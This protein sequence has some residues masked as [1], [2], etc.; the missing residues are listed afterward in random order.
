MSVME[1]TA[2]TSSTSN[3]VF[4]AR[5]RLRALHRHYGPNSDEVKN[6]KAELETA[7][8]EAYVQRLVARAPPLSDAQRA[9]LTALIYGAPATDR[10]AS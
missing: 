1:S 3:P 6:A 4:K 9:R 7:K 2:D 10:H 8:I 5:A